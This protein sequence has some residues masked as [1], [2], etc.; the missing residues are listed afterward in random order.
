MT[1]RRAKKMRMKQKNIRPAAAAA[2]CGV[3][4]ALGIVI[5]LLGGIIPVAT[6]CCPVL[7]GL[8]MIPILDAFGPAT[9]LVWYAAVGILACLLA[10]DKEAALLY[11]FLGYYPVLKLRIDRVRLSL[12]RV[13]LK[14]AVFNAATG[15]MYALLLL[16]LR[17]EGLTE[18]FRQT[19]PVLLEAMLALGNVTFLLFDLVLRRLQTLYRLRLRP[20]LRWLYGGGGK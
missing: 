16:V 18:E 9:A 4:G 15:L 7:V 5:M 19:S 17:P 1:D 2:L 12:V 14:L 13:V 20:R 3:L 10:P 11:C 6:F 8:L